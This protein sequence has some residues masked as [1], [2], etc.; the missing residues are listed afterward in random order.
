MNIIDTHLHVWNLEKVNYGWLK[1]ELGILYKNYE[2]DVIP[3]LLENTL[4]KKIVL[5][6]A[7]NSF[8]DTDYMLEGA[9][10]HNFVAGV[11]GWL[12]LSNPIQTA[13][14]LEK[15]K[16]NPYFKGVRHLIHDEPDPKWLLQEKVMESLKILA[17]N[18]IPFDVVGVLPAHLACVDRVG[19]R[20]PHL[21]FVL[22]HLCHPRGVLSEKIMQEWENGMRKVAQN[23]NVYAKI[24]GLGTVVAKK[25]KKLEKKDLEPAILF[26]LATFGT[27]RCLLGGDYPVSLLAESYEATWEMYIQALEENL[28]LIERTRLYWENAEKFYNLQ[29]QK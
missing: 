25:S 12:P 3:A 20:L 26:A 17:D 16:K 22:D 8:E 4:V 2:F 29:V 15:Y 10:K 27:N 21:R 13:I 24:S 11:V 5:V 28:S 7:E 1:P 9:K 19:E 6:Q 18:Q 23:P 14:Y